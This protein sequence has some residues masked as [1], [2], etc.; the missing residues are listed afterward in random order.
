M[1]ERNLDFDKVY[2]RKN[3]K[4]LKYDFAKIRNKPE[5]VLPLWVADMDFKVSSYVEDALVELAKHGIFGY[6]EVETPYFEAIKGWMKKRHNWEPDERWLIKTPGIVFALAM[7]V[8]AYTDKGDGVLIM[9]PVY[10]PFFEVIEDNER[11]VVSNELIMGED[12][13]YHIDFV[14]F[15]EKIVSENVKLFLLCNPH[16]P[17]GRVWTKEE[18]LKIGDICLKH[19]VIVVSDEIHQDFVFGDAKHT[20]FAD[21]KEEFLGITVTC[22]SPTKT[23]NL[24]GTQ[25]SNI[26]I[27]DEKIRH[28]FKKQVDAAG[29]SQCN[30]MGLVA[31]EAAY[32]YGEEWFESAK[33]YIWDNIKFIQD[34]IDKNLKGVTMTNQE[35]T[36]LVW[37]DF[38]GTGIPAEEIDRRILYEAKLWLDSGAIFGKAGEGYQ[39][40]N[41]ACPRS[42]LEEAL[43]RIRR[44]I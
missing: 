18:L 14:D 13:R 5:D 36:Y 21:I 17:G 41:A 3:T 30:V 16:N 37:L 1:S 2:N 22:T 40:I 4:S 34:Y 24:A 29:Y 15:E 23:F 33:A 10:Y 9:P 28:A 25:I 12:N 6:S 20:V 44:V 38:K 32:L 7:A 43:D 8:K 27:A 39:R 35:G 11:R 19:N 42:I 31:G 26:F